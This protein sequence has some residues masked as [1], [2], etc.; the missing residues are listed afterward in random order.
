MR[1][2]STDVAFTY[3]GRVVPLRYDGSRPMLVT[4]RLLTPLSGELQSRLGMQ[5]P[6][7]GAAG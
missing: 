4:F 7:T 2:K 1:R 5:L 6:P 3:L